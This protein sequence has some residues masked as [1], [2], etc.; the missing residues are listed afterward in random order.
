M[1]FFLTFH[2]LHQNA[3]LRN[4]ACMYYIWL[5]FSGVEISKKAS[6]L[7]TKMDYIIESHV[8]FLLLFLFIFLRHSLWSFYVAQAELEPMILLLQPIPVL[9]L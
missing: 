9:G 4:H 7:S 1:E 8:T 5:T 2:I 6:F 3:I